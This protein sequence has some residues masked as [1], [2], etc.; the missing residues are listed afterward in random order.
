MKRKVSPTALPAMY[1]KLVTWQ[2]RSRDKTK[3]FFVLRMPNDTGYEVGCVAKRNTQHLEWF[4]VDRKSE[5]PTPIQMSVARDLAV[6]YAKRVRSGTMPSEHQTAR[7]RRRFIRDALVTFKQHQETKAVVT[8][9]KHGVPTPKTPEKKK[10]LLPYLCFYNPLARR[11]DPV[12]IVHT[13]YCAR[14]DQQRKRMMKKGGASWVIEAKN[15]TEAVALQ[16]AEFDEEQKGYDTG[17]F[18][19]HGCAQPKERRVTSKTTMGRISKK[20]RA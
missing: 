20:R 15:A 16:V 11:K 9:L 13:A 12:F 4:R 17:D 14:L 10:V 6:W 19:I 3:R 5:V 8:Q 18:E 1:K 7:H 2:L